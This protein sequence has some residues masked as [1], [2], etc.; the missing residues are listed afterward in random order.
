METI[1]NMS[2]G[3]KRKYNL[4]EIISIKLDNE[5]SLELES[6]PPMDPPL[7]P[8]EG[9]IG[10]LNFFNNNPFKNMNA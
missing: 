5:I 6:T 10:K 7:G 8:D 4:P 1:N 3:V 2:T 9:I